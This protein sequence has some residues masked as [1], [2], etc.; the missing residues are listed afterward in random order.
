[1][2]TVIGSLN[3]DLVVTTKELPQQGETSFG[4]HFTTVP[5]GKGANQ[6]VAAARLGAKVQMIGCVGKDAFGDELIFNLQKENINVEHVQQIEE[7][8]TGVANIILSKGDN[9][10][11]VVPGANHAFKAAKLKSLRTAILQSKI[12][13]LQME[14]L[15][16]TIQSALEIC[17]S[18]S[19]P[20]LLNPAPALGFRKEWMDDATFVTPNEMECATIFGPDRKLALQNYPNK[21]IVT[22]GKRG[23][24][25]SD[26][27]RDKPIQMN[28]FAADVVDTTGAGDTFN[29]AFAYAISK[30]NTI[31]HAVAFANAAASLSVEKLGA[32]SGMPD[33]EAVK[34]RLDRFT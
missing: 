15:P 6:A 17:R 26:H 28:G 4:H 3:M 32:Q 7:A 27:C 12:V 16:D 21:L 19:I 30:N 23:A 2:I 25:Y 8:P 29:G 18:A 13:M 5:G 10:I 11:I 34:Q 14:I 20:V 31:R 33:L 9:R 22:L 1:M 24:Q